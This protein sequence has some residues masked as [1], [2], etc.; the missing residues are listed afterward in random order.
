MV[1]YVFVL[2]KFYEF[3]M[4]L[5]INLSIRHLLLLYLSTPP[6][7]KGIAISIGADG[8]PLACLSGKCHPIPISI[9]KIIY[10]SIHFPPGGGCLSPTYPSM[11]GMATYLGFAWQ[12][13]ATYV[14]I[15]EEMTS[16]AIFFIKIHSLSTHS[17]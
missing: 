2:E 15:L 6:T 14:F 17:L 16:H 9:S 7:Y 10:L 5:F 8:H 12:E 13:M 11:R 4:Y 1:T 3:A